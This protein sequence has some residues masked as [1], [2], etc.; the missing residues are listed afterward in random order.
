MNTIQLQKKGVPSPKYV[1]LFILGISC[2]ADTIKQLNDS[3]TPESVEQ[4]SYPDLVELDS[5]IENLLPE[6]GVP[7]LQAS[8]VKEGIVQ[9]S[10][11]YGYADFPARIAVDT[12][13]SFMLASIS[14]T[15]TAVALMQLYEQ[16]AFA[17]DEDIS[18]YLPFS[19]VHPTSNTAITFRQLLTHTA[20]IEDNWTIMR[21]S[22][23]EGDSTTPLSDFLYDYLH[24]SGAFYSQESNFHEWEPGEQYDYSN[25]GIALAGYLVESISG[26]DFSDW[27]SQHIFVPLQMHNTGWHLADLDI[28]QV[29]FPHA[30]QGENFNVIPHYGYP[31]YPNGQLRSS[32]V[33]MGIFLAMFASGGQYQGTHIL[34][35]S[36]VEEMLRIQRNDVNIGLVWTQE[37]WNEDIFM[38]HGGADDGVRTKMY[39]RAED[40][41]GFVVLMNAR[42]AS[43]SALETLLLAL[44]DAGNHLPY[45]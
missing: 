8:I 24:P 2:T 21:L 41:L 16:G 3:G 12:E 9:W 1:F 31:D 38:G 45:Q 13:N 32:A 10:K 26:M 23:S 19:V 7:G 28:Q 44:I 22:Y 20:A 42:I 30:Q 6:L 14:K 36:T 40:G 17:L 35:E 34:E 5:E 15:V 25:I 33:D 18:P 4:I 39:F 27:C 29:A 37:E 11:G 43:D